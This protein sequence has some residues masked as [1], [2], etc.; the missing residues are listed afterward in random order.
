MMDQPAE[1][2]AFLDDLRTATEG[3]LYPSE[4]DSE[5]EP[6]V[7]TA[8][9]PWEEDDTVVEQEADEFFRELR[10]HPDAAGFHALYQLLFA[11]LRD[12]RVH[13]VGEVKVRVFV[14]GEWSGSESDQRFGVQ[15]WS[16]ET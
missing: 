16:V 1:I 12:L 3:L 14:T 7:L 10:G 15:T 13:R 6:V 8:P 11:H 2:E 9:F 4:T 5:I